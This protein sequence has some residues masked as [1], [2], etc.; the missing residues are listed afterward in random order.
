[1]APNDLRRRS[2]FLHVSKR[3]LLPFM[4]LETT[5]QSLTSRFSAHFDVTR[6][7]SAFI[8]PQLVLTGLTISSDTH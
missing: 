5:V 6:L 4:A 7:L 2:A 3:L 8:F 1:M